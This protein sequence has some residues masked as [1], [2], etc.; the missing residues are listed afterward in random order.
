M[1]SRREFMMLLGGAV[2]AAWPLTARAQQAATPV[3]GF[4]HSGSPE[5]IANRVAAF[6]KGLNEIGYVE[7]RNV[8]IEYRWAHNDNNRLPELAADLV[9]R[10]VAV[11]VTLGSVPATLAAKAATA[12]IP[13]IFQSGMDPIKA[14][15]VSSLD[16]PG[17]NATGVTSM[18]AE[19]PAKLLGLLHE[20]MPRAACFAALV[21]PNN[22]ATE[23]IVADLRSAATTIGRQIEI[24]TASSNRDIDPAFASLSRKQADAL[25]VSPDPLFNDR[26]RQ[27]ITLAAHHRVPVVYPWRESAEAGGLLSYGTSIADQNRQAGIYTGRVLKGERPADLPIVRPTKFDLVINLITA[28][29]LGL[30][31]P[32]TL[33][34]RA[35]EVIE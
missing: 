21:N 14:G 2:G 5:P 30:E 3:I 27:L 33:L 28:K 10:R 15:V 20:L 24:L 7:D 35:D 8:A 23:P 19:L 13:I 17:G 11:I 31:I 34:T 12:T 18:N 32:P 1:T 9:R 29:A 6:R 16:R 22:L 25:L 26:R 4:L